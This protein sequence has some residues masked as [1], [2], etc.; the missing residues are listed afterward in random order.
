MGKIF[1][2]G[3]GKW[4][5]LLLVLVI[6]LSEKK[7]VQAARMSETVVPMLENVDFSNL[8]QLLE[9]EE[10]LEGF[11]FQGL[12]RKL[13][14]GE[15]IDKKMLLEQGKNLLLQEISTSRSY[16]VQI[17]LLMA[18]FALLYNFANVFE[19][20]AVTDVSF[21]MVYM[22]LLALLMNS[23]MLMSGV[24]ENALH[25]ILDFMQ[26]LIPAF[27]LTIVLSTG[28]ITAMGFH[29]LTM[30]LFGL[31]ESILLYAVLPAVHIYIMLE[32]LNH[33]TK[34]DLLSKMT[35]LIKS[36][37]EWVLKALFAMVLG[38]NLIQGLL[39][40]V[41]DNLKSNTLVKTAGAIPGI[42]GSVQAAT[43]I[44]VSS[45]IL[46]KN[47]VGIAGVL[48]LVAL[49]AGPLLKVGIMALLYKISAAVIQPIADKR[50]AGCVSG[51]G[52]G[53]RLLGKTLL[54]AEVMMV[55]T[56]VIVIAATTWNK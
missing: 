13:I 40:P 9:E 2:V 3:L 19:N 33:M 25:K 17:V 43:E 31:V 7:E 20:A 23:F 52:E 47:G 51:M 5:W 4:K 32:L 12:V 6:V 26:A 55:L 54:M 21:Y 48:I 45:G 37:I 35:E 42:G 39:S 49:C 41:I 28:T 10:L 29:Q 44:M 53:A 16:M 14:Q 46:I 27:S 56:I 11:D 30:F 24:L 18:A 8:N 22:I 1:G 15:E 38:M 34:E 36:G 50:L